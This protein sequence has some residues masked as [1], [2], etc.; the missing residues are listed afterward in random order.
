MNPVIN[1]EKITD[2]QCIIRK[3]ERLPEKARMY[4]AGYVEG[5]ADASEQSRTE[6][7]REGT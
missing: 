6:E 5:M 3:L 1:M 7:R 4:V 2:V